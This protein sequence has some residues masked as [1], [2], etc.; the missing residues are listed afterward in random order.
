[1]LAVR[2]VLIELPLL[3]SKPPPPV[4]EPPPLSSIVAPPVTFLLDPVGLV[5][6]NA[7]FAPTSP[8]VGS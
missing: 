4:T 7:T 3:L 1:M 6:L 8:F 5:V 2:E